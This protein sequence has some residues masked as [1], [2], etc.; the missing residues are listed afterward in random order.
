M[1]RSSSPGSKAW[2]QTLHSRCSSSS[3]P[4]PPRS[5]PLPAEA[6]P[7]ADAPWVI[8]TVLASSA[9]WSSPVAGGSVSSAPAKNSW[10]ASG[11]RATPLS[12]SPKRRPRTAPAAPITPR[13]DGSGQ[14]G[15][16]GR[17]KAS[18]YGAGPPRSIGP[19]DA[20]ERAAKAPRS[21]CGRMGPHEGPRSTPAAQAAQLGA[22]PQ[23][24]AGRPLAAA[25]AP[26]RASPAL[27]TKLSRSPTSAAAC[28]A[29]APSSSS[30][31]ASANASS[32]GSERAASSS[33][34]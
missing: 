30:L 18:E 12:G 2:R 26:C 1:R 23:P 27:A 34:A 16:W 22:A 32:E 6:A 13:C 5:E 14:P 4:P 28:P 25:H 21:W 17:W 10:S 7:P 33:S 19:A 9:A 29:A 8:V 31:T 24:G 11:S 20:N 3:A 15:G